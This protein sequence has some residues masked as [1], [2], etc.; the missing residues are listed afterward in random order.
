MPPP[1]DSSSCPA[2][3]VTPRHLAGDDD[4]L[5][6]QVG[7]H[8]TAAGWTSLTLVRGRREPDE[9]DD[10]RQV[11]RSTVLYVA[12]DALSWAQW[13]LAD[14]PILLGD[15]P[16]AW[17]VSA[18]ATPESLPQWNAYFSAGT[19]HEVVT[20]FLLALENRPDPAHG[21]A[22]P[23]AVLDALAGG[24]WVRDVDTSAAMS[25]P[26]LA[27]SMAFTTLPDE[28]IQD[29]DPFVLDPEGEAAG[30]QAWCEPRMGAGLLW[31]VMFSASTPHD[32]V[33]A[34]AGSLASPAPVLR[35]TLPESSEGQLTVQPT[36]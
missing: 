6:D 31:A 7:S 21:Y 13:V 35:H 33:A 4:L 29:G 5:A 27:A 34:F 23:Q 24:G 12:A 25:D 20:D 30:W 1:P 22:A 28:G 3:W 19:P 9:S 18:R 36:V 15:Q 32:L 10:A 8:L 11:L 2:Y 26:Q 16:V 14:E 17:T